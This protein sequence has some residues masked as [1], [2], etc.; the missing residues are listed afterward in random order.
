MTDEFSV[1]VNIEPMG[2]R[3]P[4]LLVRMMRYR[5]DIWEATINDKKGTPHILQTVIFFYPQDDNRKHLLTDNN[6]GVTSVHFTYEIMKAELNN[7]RMLYRSIWPANSVQNLT[8][9]NKK[10]FLCLI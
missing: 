3:D 1:I 9:C 4:A 7:C 5:S 2:Y 6:N 8:I 10:W